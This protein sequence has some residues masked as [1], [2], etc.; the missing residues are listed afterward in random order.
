[1]ASVSI[2][3]QNFVF[4]FVPQHLIDF[5]MRYD[6]SSCPKFLKHL[7]FLACSSYLFVFTAYSIHFVNTLFSPSALFYSFLN[8]VDVTF[9]LYASFCIL[10]NLEHCFIFTKDLILAAV[11]F[12]SSTSHSHTIK[13]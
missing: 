13:I 7:Y 2:T 5:I 9:Y 6:F 11:L 8:I 3:F 10:S 4:Y 12:I 1:M